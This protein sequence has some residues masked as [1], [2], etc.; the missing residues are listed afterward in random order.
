MFFPLLL[1]AFLPESL[2]TGSLYRNTAGI[3]F[4]DSSRYVFAGV[5]ACASKCHNNDTMGYQLDRWRESRHAS[6]FSVLLTE[7]AGKYAV[8][9]GL[10]GNPGESQQCLACH[11]TAAGCDPSSVGET[12]R[13]E[14]GVTC[15]ACHKGE[16]R[17]VTWIPAESDCRVCHRSTV[18]KVPDFNFKEALKIISH[19]RPGTAGDGSK[20]PESR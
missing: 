10:N 16:F 5:D 14:E 13:R 1:L 15:E 2:P 19:P 6:A 8:R 7:K 9:A 17:P 3:R 11:S 18:H 4:S 20:S 12:F